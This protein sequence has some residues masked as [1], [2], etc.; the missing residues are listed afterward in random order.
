MMKIEFKIL[1]P[2]EFP[3]WFIEG[4]VAQ[5]EINEKIIGYFGEVHPRILKNWKIKMPVVLCEL[6]LAEVFERVK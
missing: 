5:L 1:T 6:D 2:K 3:D 4:R